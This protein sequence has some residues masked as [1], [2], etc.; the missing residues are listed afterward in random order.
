MRGERNELCQGIAIRSLLQT[1]CGVRIR[2]KRPS[3]TTFSACAKI[4]R[5][6][7][8]LCLHGV[9]IR[10]DHAGKWSRCCWGLWD[11]QLLV[12]SSWAVSISPIGNASWLSSSCLSPSHPPFSFSLSHPI[13]PVFLPST[14]SVGA[15]AGPSCVRNNLK[16][17]EGRGASSAGG[18]GW[19]PVPCRCQVFSILLRMCPKPAAYWRLQV[20]DLEHQGQGLELYLLPWSWN[21]QTYGAVEAGRK[22]TSP[23]SYSTRRRAV[24]A[25]WPINSS[26]HL[27][28]VAGGMK[29]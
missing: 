5:G 6:Q 24:L 23:C 3:S 20:L 22:G 17:P 8:P 21:S 11:Q 28:K 1:S 16:P 19:H 26:N 2:N 13:L 15:K 25:N 18:V 27:E 29:A 4:I 10:W 14:L 7:A 9:K 12:G